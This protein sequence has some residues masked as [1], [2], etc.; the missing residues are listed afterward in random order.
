M[1]VGVQCLLDGYL[2]TSPQQV[3][4]VGGRYTSRD[5]LRQLEQHGRR[6]A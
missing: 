1:A 4:A 3:E 2:H 5:G 6:A